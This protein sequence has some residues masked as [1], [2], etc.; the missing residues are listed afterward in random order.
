MFLVAREPG[1]QLLLLLAG[2]NMPDRPKA[3][4]FDV[5]PESLDSLRGAFPEWEI[6]VRNGAALGALS[7]DRDSEAADLLVLG[8]RDQIVETLRMCRRVRS[9]PGRAHTPLVVLVRPAQEALVRA[10]LAAG[11][12]SCLVLPVH[13]KE[14]ASMV[15]RARANNQPGRHTLSLER[16]QRKDHW[17]DDGGEG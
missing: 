3:I 11:A 5:D 7:G 12:D 9:Q 13:V 1:I 4:A 10:A 8:A 2:E 16:S 17:R 6:E 14:L 15:T